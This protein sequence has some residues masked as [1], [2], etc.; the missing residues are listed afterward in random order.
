MEKYI[1][2]EMLL[3]E[4]LEVNKNQTKIIHR[5]YIQFFNQLRFE[6]NNEKNFNA[7][8]YICNWHKL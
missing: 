8:I 3:K 7:P 1:S 4:A 2:A 5:K 6:E